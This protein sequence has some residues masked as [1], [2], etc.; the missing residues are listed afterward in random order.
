MKIN[1]ARVVILLLTLLPFV[2]VSCTNYQE[3]EIPV[4]FSVD[5][6][7]L[8]FPED[9]G[10]SSLSV[11]S[12]AKWD[13]SSMP[14]WINL[15]TINR[16]DKSPYE[17]AISFSTSVNNDFDREGIITI[18]SKSETV[19]VYVTQDGKKGGFVAVKSISVSPSEL[20]LTKG[21]SASLSCIINP[22][23][24]SIKNITWKSSS[25]SVATVS[26]EGQVEAI[27]DGVAV[28]TVTA[29]DGGKTA[30]CM[31][32][33]N[34]ESVSSVSLDKES[35]TLK[36]GESSTLTATILPENAANKKVSWSSSNTSIATVDSDG[37]V[38]ALGIGS[39]SITVTT[40]DG[41]KTA[42]CQV[43]VKEPSRATSLALLGADVLYS[44]KVGKEF[45]ISVDVKPEDALVDLEWSVSDESLA[46]ISEDGSSITLRAKD[47]GPS[48][49]MA[50]DKISGLSASEQMIAGLVDFYW[51]ENTGKTF[52]GCPLVE[53]EVGEERRLSCFYKPE[54]ATRVFR[55][56]MNG[57]WY[58]E[59]LGDDTE[60]SDIPLDHPSFFSIDENGTITGIK[61]GLTK[62]CVHSPII[63][64]NAQDLYVRVSNTHRTPEAVD[65]GLS[66]KWSSFDLDASE[67]GGT[68]PNYSW[69]EITS[70]NNGSWDLYKWC[71]GSKN[72]LTKYNSRKDHGIVDNLITL[73]LSDDAASVKLGGK[74]RIPNSSEWEELRTEC[75]WT[76][77]TLN[78]YDG[79]KVQSKKPGFTDK[80]IFLP[81]SNGWGYWGADLS[82]DFDYSTSAYRVYFTHRSESY[83]IGT[84]RVNPCR[85]RPVYGDLKPET[86]ISVSLS[87]TTLFLQIGETST[88]SL[89]LLPAN[90]SNRSVTWSSSNTTVATVSSSGLVTAKSNGLALI[91]VTTEDGGKTA[92]CQVVV[93]DITPTIPAPEAVDMG[94]S[95]KWASFNIGASKPE[96]YGDYYAWGETEAKSEY[97]W[98]TYKFGTSASGPLTKYNTNSSYGTVDNMAKLELGPYG[99]DVASKKL[100]GEWRMPTREEWSELNSRCT[101][102]WAT[103][104][105]VNGYQVTATNGNSIFLP[106][107]G[108]RD[109]TNLIY[110]GRI[111]DYWSSSL[112]TVAPSSSWYLHLTSDRVVSGEFVGYR[113]YGFSVRPVK[114]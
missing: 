11:R 98:S 61:E 91:T 109:S 59:P 39:A 7:E 16:S 62:I 8:L 40:E 86:V 26:S 44:A 113:Y 2:V 15:E 69:G 1:T 18:K 96:E 92:S 104:N 83:A 85:I 22:T 57:F 73:E 75:T 58:Y 94:L 56:D 101:W 42:V 43:L 38:M 106:A 68:G 77:T 9:G 17:W 70:D 67:L 31:V 32:T 45:T 80:W 110:E 41:G 47:Y 114:E 53:I 84:D 33:V 97:G 30:S 27:A 52:N 12:G 93:N 107:A 72:T 112:D 4:S 55:S 35:L 28:I 74:W 82:S 89:I 25:S 103:R 29:E 71:N 19:D 54:Y 50:R 24:A 6:K 64:N 5:A 14:S 3:E 23:N 81:Y 87:K 20:S 66:V 46:E 100:G 65:L 10:K 76:W 60:I 48:T 105:G 51:T 108:Y 37:I 111:G 79:V 90:A 95:V 88:L 21:E 49:L 36:V 13:V 63:L 78:G 34:P 99:D 102:V